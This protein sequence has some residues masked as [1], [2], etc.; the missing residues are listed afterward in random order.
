MTRKQ[1]KALIAVWHLA[2]YQGEALHRAL[3]AAAS[4]QRN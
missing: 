2:L 3:E 4:R 1:I